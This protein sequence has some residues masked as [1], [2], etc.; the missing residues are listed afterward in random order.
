MHLHKGTPLM[1]TFT[2]VIPHLSGQNRCME[3]YLRQ[4]R[5]ARGMSIR[6]LSQRSRVA[7]SYIELIEIGEANPTVKIM[8]RLANAL[9]V[10]V[11]ELFSCT[12]KKW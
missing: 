1:V 11:Q 9:N 8:C 2:Y 3:Y 4:I 7:A 5:E 6:Q 10:Q 12:D